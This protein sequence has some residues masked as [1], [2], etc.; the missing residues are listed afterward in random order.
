MQGARV[1]A[2]ATAKELRLHQRVGNGTAI[3]G[4]EREAGARA[5]R[6]DGARRQFLAAAGLAADGHRRA[7]AGN[8]VHLR[9]QRLHGG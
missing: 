9:P 8:A 5:L 1:G 6:M 4:N 7:T 3:D 2:L